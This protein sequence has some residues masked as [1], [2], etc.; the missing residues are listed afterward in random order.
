M[1]EQDVNMD[2]LLMHMTAC[3]NMGL[4]HTRAALDL[5]GNG[6]AHGLADLGFNTAFVQHL[7]EAHACVRFRKYLKEG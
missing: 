6:C 4:Q 2:P 3:V 5:R 1:E 7:N